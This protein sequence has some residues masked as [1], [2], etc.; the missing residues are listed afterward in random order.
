MQKVE[1]GLERVLALE[2]AM[3]QKGYQLI[4]D[5]IPSFVS[6]WCVC[7][8]DQHAPLQILEFS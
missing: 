5:H 8:G 7:M 6:V 3:G 1:A 4:L 2:G